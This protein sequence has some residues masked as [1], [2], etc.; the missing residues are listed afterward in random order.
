RRRT[1]EVDAASDVRID[2]DLIGEPG[3]YDIRAGAR[4]GAD[5]GIV[6]AVMIDVAVRKGP[7]VAGDRAGD[8]LGVRRATRVPVNL[9][10]RV[11]SGVPTAGDRQVVRLR[12]AAAVGRLDLIV[13]ADLLE[14]VGL[15][16]PVL[17]E[18]GE[19]SRPRQV[20]NV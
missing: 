9:D 4:D 12:R 16:L 19:P 13:V 11:V 6:A 14:D 17:V 20:K 10:L 7:G 15:L 2:V 5:I 18:P 1:F 8:G 3:Q